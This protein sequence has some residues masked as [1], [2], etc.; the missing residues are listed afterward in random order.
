M[1][2]SS[3][4]LGLAWATGLVVL[5]AATF[6]FMEPR[7]KEWNEAG[8][9][10]RTARRRLEL[11]ERAASQRPKWESRMAELRVRLASYSA[12]KDVT[13]E[14]M[15]LIE[16]LAR[17]GDFKLL[18]RKPGKEKPQGDLFGMA[19]DCTWEGPLEALRSFLYA[20]ETQNVTVDAEELSFSVVPNGKGQLKGNLSINCVFVRESPAQTQSA[21]RKTNWPGPG[22]E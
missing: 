18:N 14:Y 15:K 2:I 5:A 9:R 13:A 6:L 3:R 8:A 22:E 12:D 16:R 19:I 4:E 17:D 20:L 7:V 1:K 10:M 11:A 21:T